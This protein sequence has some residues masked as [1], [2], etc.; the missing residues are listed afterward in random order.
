M[1][2]SQDPSGY[3]H[4]AAVD[5]EGNR[6]GKVSRM[7]AAPVLQRPA[8][9][10]REDQKVAGIPGNFVVSVPALALVTNTVHIGLHSSPLSECPF[11]VIIGSGLLRIAFSARPHGSLLS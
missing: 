4:R 9:H 1:A 6:I 8:R 2:T 7:F 11:T 3:I 5:T 10:R